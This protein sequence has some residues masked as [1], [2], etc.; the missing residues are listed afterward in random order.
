MEEMSDN[1][2][3][4]KNKKIKVIEKIVIGLFFVCLLAKCT[5]NSEEH[6]SSEISTE[7]TVIESVEVSEM[8]TAEAAAQTQVMEQAT[9]TTTVVTYGFDNPAPI[10]VLQTVKTRALSGEY[11]AEI[12]LTEVKRGQEALDIIMAENSLNTSPEEGYE[13]ILAKVYFKNID[14]GEGKSVNINPLEFQAFSAEG[15]QYDI[16]SSIGVVIPNNIRGEVYKGAEKEGYVLFVTKVGDNPKV[17]YGT[18]YDGT[19]GIWFKLN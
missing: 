17:S 13:Y 8:T 2:K 12:K 4:D 5:Q 18:S 10:G 19:G 9:E 3:D 15:V 11:T 6:S 14:C 16:T 7:T 1:K